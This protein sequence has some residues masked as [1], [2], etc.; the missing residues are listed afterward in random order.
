MA[1]KRKK[2]TANALKN[3]TGQDFAENYDEW[4]SWWSK[5][6]NGYEKK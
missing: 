1:N 4:Y 2:V 3:I 5:N 6:K